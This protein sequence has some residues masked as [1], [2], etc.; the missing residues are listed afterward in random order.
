VSRSF[1]STRPSGL[2]QSAEEVRGSLETN[3]DSPGQATGRPQAGVT[4]STRPAVTR[5]LTPPLHS[6]DISPP[7]SAT[8][9]EV[10]VVRILH[11]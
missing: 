4:S 11:G 3:L 8:P 9:P 1:P 6:H 2:D 5:P 10:A 7:E